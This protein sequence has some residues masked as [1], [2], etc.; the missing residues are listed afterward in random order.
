M[1]LKHMS[2]VHQCFSTR[3]IL[4]RDCISITLT[5]TTTNTQDSC[6]CCCHHDKVIMRV[7]PVEHLMIV[8]QCQVSVDP[9]NQPSDLACEA[10]FT[11]TLT[12]NE[13]HF[14]IGR[15]VDG[16]VELL[17]HHILSHLVTSST[18]TFT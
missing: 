13:I 10:E 18:D 9:H 7:H 2:N 3:G 1:F 14:I 11:I 6:L 15:M 12:K 17:C 4:V 8:G 16:R 5:L